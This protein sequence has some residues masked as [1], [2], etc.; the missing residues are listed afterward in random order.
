MEQTEHETERRRKGAVGCNGIGIGCTACDY[1][2]GV[3]GDCNCNEA[4]ALSDLDQK[5]R[6]DYRIQFL[7]LI[8]FIVRSGLPTLSPLNHN[9]CRLQQVAR[10]GFQYSSMIHT[11]TYNV[12]GV[13]FQLGQQ[14]FKFMEPQLGE[15]SNSSDKSRFD[16]SAPQEV[17]NTSQSIEE[18]CSNACPMD[19]VHENRE[20][21]LKCKPVLRL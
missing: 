21:N 16:N 14:H 7:E 4:F 5:Q 9:Y 17:I 13:N 1:Y 3:C 15:N 11:M 19:V 12:N 2:I 6:D 10:M 20:D 8:R 18:S